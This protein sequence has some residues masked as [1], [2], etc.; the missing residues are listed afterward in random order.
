MSA[1]S[2]QCPLPLSFIEVP[3]KRCAAPYPNPQNKP[4]IDAKGEGS[5]AAEWLQAREKLHAIFFDEKSSVDKSKKKAPLPLS[6][7]VLNNIG[8]IL[9]EGRLADVF[10]GS[11]RRDAVFQEV[12]RQL[13]ETTKLCEQYVLAEA[14]HASAAAPAATASTKDDEKEKVDEV[15]APGSASSS[16]RYH[17]IECPVEGSASDIS[18]TMTTVLRT[19][20]QVGSDKE[21][22]QSVA[23]GKHYYYL[24]TQSLCAKTHSAGCDYRYDLASFHFNVAALYSN[25]AAYLSQLCCGLTN[26]M[27]NKLSGTFAG[28]QSSSLVA[29]EGDY[30]VQSALKDGYQ[31][32]CAAA[33]HFDVASALVAAAIAATPPVNHESANAGQ[34]AAYMPDMTPPFLCLLREVML[35]QAQEMAACKSFSQGSVLYLPKL[36]SKDAHGN[37]AS[38]EIGRSMGAVLGDSDAAF[39][40]PLV[41]TNVLLSCRLYSHAAVVFERAV[42][43]IMN[44][45]VPYDSKSWGSEYTMFKAALT[46]KASTI[47][48]CVAAIRGAFMATPLTR[49]QHMV[50]DHRASAAKPAVSSTLLGSHPGEK[51][52]DGLKWLRAAVVESNRVFQRALQQ[53]APSEV[54]AWAACIFSCVVARHASHCIDTWGQSTVSKNV[55]PLPEMTGDPTITPLPVARPKPYSPTGRQ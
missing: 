45:K 29:M 7:I 3:L 12:E 27:P 26:G 39:T 10:G 20:T 43:D 13:A 19:C 11:H 21:T 1:P 16:T 46:L 47:E 8:H 37:S 44:T 9:S 41:L 34:P 22:L 14:S 15:L 42:R 51:Y 30:G 4:T 23:A 33:N 25:C 36:D 32:L 54:R 18:K 49:N 6:A 40:S 48:L 24:W 38:F 53:R 31:Y 55:E 28:W 2:S 5:P 52:E 50:Y 17:F 35:G